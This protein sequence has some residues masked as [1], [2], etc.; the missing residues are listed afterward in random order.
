MAESKKVSKKTK[1]KV[2]KVQKKSLSKFKITKPN[3]RVI[4]RENIGDYIK[5]YEAKGCKVEE[6]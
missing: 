3:G 6:I 4:Y 1:K 2:E 5:T